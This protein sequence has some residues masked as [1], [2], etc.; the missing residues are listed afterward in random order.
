MR[1][2]TR[3]RSGPMPIASIASTSSYTCIVPSS[4]VNAAPIA[5]R[6]H[7]AGEQR[8]KFT[9]ESD[10]NQAGHQTFRAE[11]FQLVAGQQRHGQS[12]EKRNHRDQRDRAD[13]GAFGVAKKTRR[14]EMDRG[15]A[16]RCPSFRRTC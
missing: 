10:R 4:A 5:R 2:A 3:N 9:G 14:R 7:D 6:E 13:T 15:R 8:S 16:A 11:T 1:G 12:E